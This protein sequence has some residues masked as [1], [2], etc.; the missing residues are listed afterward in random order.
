M[1]APGLLLTFR[2][3][4]RALCVRHGT[5][6]DLVA[7]G[8]LRAVPWFGSQRI[9]R[10]ELERLARQGVTPTGRPPRGR[11]ARRHVSGTS[12]AIRNLDVRTL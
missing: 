10:E 8:L 6:A 12:E 11:Q 4:D 1:S 5:A 2:A 9:P 7:R 3:A